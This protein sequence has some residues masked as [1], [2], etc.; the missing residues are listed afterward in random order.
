MRWT[1]PRRSHIRNIIMC[2]RRRR[3]RDNIVVPLLCRFACARACVCV[4]VCIIRSIRF[5]KTNRGIIIHGENMTM[6]RARGLHA[7]ARTPRL[8]RR[9][10]P[11]WTRAIFCRRVIIYNILLY[12]M[13]YIY[14]YFPPPYIYTPYSID[15]IIF[16]QSSRVVFC[17]DW[18]PFPLHTCTPTII[19]YTWVRCYNIV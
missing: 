7:H 5:A 8:L 19:I 18:A 12:C 6:N 15:I 2:V 4:R 16:I 13:L 3:K 1:K 11:S 9:R 10:A 14:F 17:T